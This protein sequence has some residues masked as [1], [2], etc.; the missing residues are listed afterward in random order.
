MICWVMF[1]W[2]EPTRPTRIWMCS[3]LKNLFASSCAAS[4]KVAEN[5]K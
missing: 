5:M 1:L 4:E 2:V 3:V